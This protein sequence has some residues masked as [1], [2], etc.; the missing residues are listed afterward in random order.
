MYKLEPYKGRSTRHICPEC[1]SRDKTFVRYIDDNGNYLSNVV[2]R[3][4]RESKCGYH[5]TPKQYFTDNPQRK[6]DF[7]PIFSPQSKKIDKPLCFISFEYVR[8]AKSERSNFITFVKTLFDEVDI[9]RV[10][11]DYHLGVTKSGDT[12]FWQIDIK[13]N[14][15]TG[16]IQ[17]YNPSTG[18]R[19]KGNP[20]RIDWVHSKLKKQGNLPSDWELTQCL[21]GEHLLSKYPTKPVA[22]V[23]GEKNAILGAI[24]YGD[25]IW[26]ATG[27]KQA[28]TYDK[29]KVLRGRKIIIYPDTDSLNEWREKAQKISFLM[30][31]KISDLLNQEASQ[32]E[33][34]Q[35][36]DMADYIIKQVKQQVNI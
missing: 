29:L 21:F 35:G 3:C 14:V 13:G 9:K 17:G 12:I 19:I 5:Y 25:C 26:L 32:E 30:S 10:I 11:D 27:N 22:I 34:K 2:G 31:A 6:S 24:Y 36:F 1:Q 18:K 4:N 15:R 7:K 23:E 28:F 16:K 8:Q 20:D 33:I